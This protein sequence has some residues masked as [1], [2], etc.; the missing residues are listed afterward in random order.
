MASGPIAAAVQ[1][2]RDWLRPRVGEVA[3][4]EHRSQGDRNQKQIHPSLL[5]AQSYLGGRRGGRPQ[6]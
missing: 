4:H 6:R 3:N 2:Q 1:T 5:L